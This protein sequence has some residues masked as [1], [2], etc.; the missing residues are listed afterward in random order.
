[1]NPIEYS[2]VIPVFNSDNALEK[3][4][5]IICEFFTGKNYLFEVIY[6]DDF[7]SDNSWEVLKKIKHKSQANISL[8][9]MSK[10]FGQHAA[11]LC[12]FKYAK[13]NFIFTMDD[14]LE[15]HPVEITKLIEA[16]KSGNSDLI[17]GVYAKRNISFP[18]SI[19]TKSFKLLS[20]IEGAHNGKGSSFRMLKHGLAKKLVENHKQFT[21]IDELCLWY[22][23]KVVSIQVESN[24]DYITKK[25]YS[26]GGLLR[27]SSTIIM[28]SSTFP[29]KLVTNL[30]LI[31]S[32]VNFLIGLNFLIKKIFFGT[33]VEGFTSLIVSILFSTGLIIFCIGIIAQYL[34]KVLKSVNNAPAYNEDEIIC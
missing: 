22:T 3:L 21:F 28:F 15:V 18:R 26:I 31:L 34:S 1:M 13:G 29:L 4:N 9:R 27:M 17:Y 25:R 6:V 12:G 30:G 7:S 14:D 20:K 11:T 10:N 23:R 32:L 2:I 16:Q 33:P 19:L 24:P 8:V 5:N